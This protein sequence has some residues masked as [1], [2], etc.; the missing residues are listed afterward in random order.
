[1]KKVIACLLMALVCGGLTAQAQ[2]KAKDLGNKLFEE[3]SAREKMPDVQVF[4]VPEMADLQMLNTE[5]E[6]FGPYQYPLVK[7]VN[8]M[9]NGEID[10]AK[11][12][13]LRNAAME[14]GADLIIEPMYNSVVY[15]NDNQVI[16]T[17]LSGYPAK[18]VNFRKIT[19][20]DMEIIRTLYPHGIGDAYS[21]R[22]AT[23]IVTTAAAQGK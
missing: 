1:M 16:W 14:A 6:T 18:Y 23:R 19:A 2:K 20:Q 15:D 22:G 7:D 10:N 12:I 13:A 21:D 5:R 17:T 4:I 8:S 9:T 11:A 3:A